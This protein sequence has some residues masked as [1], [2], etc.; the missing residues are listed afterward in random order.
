MSRAVSLPKLPLVKALVD[1]VVLV[2]VTIG[3]RVFV[4]VLLLF[5]SFVAYV[6]DGGG[7][8]CVGRGACYIF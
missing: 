3:M 4:R 8:G 2:V 6:V 5:L 1:V 7:V